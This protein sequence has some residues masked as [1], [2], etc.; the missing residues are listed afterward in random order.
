MSVKQ[1]FV[2][3]KEIP[4]RD[5]N[6]EDSSFFEHFFTIIDQT[7][8]QIKVLAVTHLVRRLTASIVKGVDDRLHFNVFV[9]DFNDDAVSRTGM[10][11]Q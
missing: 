9:I 5:D 10:I 2:M 6:S 4:M 1:L 11:F 7:A 8:D 3:P